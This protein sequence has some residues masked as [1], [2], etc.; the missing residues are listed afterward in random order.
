MANPHRGEVGLVVG[1]KE[2]T[3]ALTTNGLCDLQKRTGKTYGELLASLGRLD[4]VALRDVMKTLLRKHHGKQ[5]HD[6]SAVGD[7]IDDAGGLSGLTDLL[8]DILSLN[9]PPDGDD[10]TEGG[11]GSDPP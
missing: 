5:F 1:D 7:L 11:E 3:L 6:E 9:Q 10:A 4:M 8:K 2:F